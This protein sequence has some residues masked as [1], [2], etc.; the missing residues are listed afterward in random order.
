M[1]GLAVSLLTWPLAVAS[2]HQSLRLKYIVIVSRHGVRAPTWDAG[3]LNQYSTA[4]WP[5]WAVPPGDLTPHGRALI[6]QMG[7]YY[8][9]WL[10]SEQFLGGQGCQDAKRIYIWADT[11]ERTIETGR[12]FAESL[13]PGC[14]LATHSNPQG[15]KD[16][17]FSGIGKPD[18]E[19]SLKAVRDRLAPDSQELAVQLRSAFDTLQFVLNGNETGAKDPPPPEEISASLHGSSVELNDQLDVGSTLSEDLLLEYT[20]GMRG[21]NLGWGRLTEE[22]LLHILQ[23]HTV[24]SDLTRRTPY[25]ARAKGANLL[26]HVLRSM[27]QAAGGKALPGALG[28]PG[29]SLLILVGHDTN[30]LNISGILALKWQLG[31][32]GP[33]ETPPG[34]ALI[35]SLWQDSDSRQYFVRTQFVVQ[36]LEQMHSGLPLS[37]SSPPAKQDVSIPGCGRLT[38]TTGCPWPLFKAAVERA[39]DPAFVSSR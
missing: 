9:D 6:K 16:P 33:N 24:H 23:I 21:A 26:A 22:N 30:L 37:L 19:L 25:L 10:S 4:P 7:S 5:K 34:G 18:P 8:R 2:P 15:K 13:L 32:Y 38:Q 17:V 36:T 31:G 11:D 27:E 14:S 3:R 39:L 28:D 35:F 12:A 1:A 29:D 20:D